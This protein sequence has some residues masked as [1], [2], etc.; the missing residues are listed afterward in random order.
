MNPIVGPPIAPWDRL[1]FG[2]ISV[3]AAVLVHPVHSASGQALGWA[4]E[5]LS[6]M[7]LLRS[8]DNENWT[9]ETAWEVARAY[10]A[11]TE[12]QTQIRGAIARDELERIYQDERRGPC[13]GNAL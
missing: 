7:K 9:A 1:P 3:D 2:P 13:L 11:S 5:V 8:W 4:C 10:I 6:G 12:G